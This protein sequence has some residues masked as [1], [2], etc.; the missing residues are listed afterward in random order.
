MLIADPFTIICNC[1]ENGVP[2]LIIVCLCLYDST[3]VAA[4]ILFI[5]IWVSF[6]IFSSIS[7]AIFN[8]FL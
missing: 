7:K 2:S 5:C 3:V 8:E 1:I 4:M 6:F